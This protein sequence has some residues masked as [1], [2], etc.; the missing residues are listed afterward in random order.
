MNIN[1]YRYVNQAVVVNRNN[2]YNVNNYNDV[3]IKNVDKST[4]VKN[5]RAAPVINNTVINDYSTLKQKYNY[6][7]VNVTEKPQRSVVNRIEHNERVARQGGGAKASGIERDLSTLREGRPAQGAKIDAPTVRNRLVP[8]NEV[9]RTGSELK[10]RERDIK[11]KGVSKSEVPAQPPGGGDKPSTFEK[12]GREKIQPPLKGPRQ[13]GTPGQVGEPGKVREPG[14]VG[15][16]GQEAPRPE[17]VRSPLT[18]PPQQVPS[19]QSGQPA[20][21][22]IRRG[23]APGADFATAVSFGSDGTTR[24]WGRSEQGQDPDAV[25]T[26]S[27]RQRRPGGQTRFPGDAGSGCAASRTSSTHTAATPAAGFTRAGRAVGPGGKGV[28]KS[29]ASRAGIPGPVSLR[30]DGTTRFAGTGQGEKPAD[31]PVRPGRG[32]GAVGTTRAEPGIPK[33]ADRRGR[34]PGSAGDNNPRANRILQPQESGGR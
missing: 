32:S 21:V 34:N 8:G 22:G 33:S 28:Q 24:W 13:T 30:F 15:A 31:T 26:W 29:S 20:W 23:P 14:Q 18:Q 27:A 12:P 5:Y 11:E 6:T 25:R 1:R 3:R 2:F 16:P 7:N 9:P 19:G 10:A 17:R 4:I